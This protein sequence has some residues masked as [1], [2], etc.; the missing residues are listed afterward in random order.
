M[1]KI[2]YFSTLIAGFIGVVDAAE[3]TQN[4]LLSPLPTSNDYDPF[5]SAV[6]LSMVGTVMSASSD[7]SPEE[8]DRSTPIGAVED[9]LLVSTVDDEI[10]TD[11]NNE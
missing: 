4:S 6:P 5:V 10:A 8:E 9:P 11:N 2:I 1:K 7:A 3:D